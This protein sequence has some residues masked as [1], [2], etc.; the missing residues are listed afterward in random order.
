MMKGTRANILEAIGGTPIIK[1]NKVATEVESEIYVKLEYMNPGGS[2]KDRIGK[3]MLDQALKE[4][5][6]HPGGT[7]IEGTSG[8]TGVGLAMW[9]A[10]YGFK[11]IF[12]LADKQ[13]REKIDNLRAFG[14]KVVVCPTDVAPED[15]RSYYSVSKRLAQTIPNSFYVNQYDNLHNRDTHYTWTA[16]EIFEQTAGDFDAFICGIGTGGTIT[17]CGRYFKEKNPNVQIVGVDPEGSI[18][19]DYF[20]TGKMVP[21]KSYVI[22]GI[23]EDFIPQNY[24]FSTIDDIVTVGD[25]ESFIMTRRLLKQEGI[26]AGGSSGAAVLGAIKWARTQK[27]PKKILVLMHDSGNRYSSKIYNDDWMSDKGYLEG[28]FNIQITDLLRDLGKKGQLITID[29][30]ATIGDAIA[31]MDKHGISQLPVLGEGQI[32]G[33]V[34]ERNLLRPIMTGEFSKTDSIS[35]AYSSNYRIVDANDLLAN[36]ADALIKKGVALVTEKGKLISILTDIDVLQYVSKREH[37]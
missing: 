18:L 34:T 23:G 31:I 3:Y 19:A 28:S 26:Y 22:E 15:P 6:L 5:K 4:G 30:N 24:D 25:K 9:A 33:L 13:S 32:K 1:L 11:C 17:G 12:V 8:N 27:T 36:V 14:A 20:K 35:L 10:I 29:D 16:P 37:S 21:A 7:I 2:T